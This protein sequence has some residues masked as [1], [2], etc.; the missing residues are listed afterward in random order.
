MLLFGLL[1]RHGE[2]LQAQL[3]P[4]V[5][6]ADREALARAKLI[7][8]GKRGRGFH[9]NLTDTG[10]AWVA[11]HLSAELPPQQ[12]ALSDLLGRLAEHLSR[13]N[14]TLADF[15]GD[16]P[17]ETPPP[18][19]SKPPSPATLRKRIEAAYLKITD[20]RRD[21]AVRLS[22]LR[23]ELSDL[24]RPTVDAALAR[25]LKGD[26]S[27]SLMRQDD[28]RQLNQADRDAAF[29]PAGDPFHV[30]WISS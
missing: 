25:I 22:L 17:E 8:V 15:I 26:K 29:S 11:T 3:A 19:P 10:W 21:E 28:P 14:T 5:K 24:D 4:A 2:S 20:G 23:A 9:L 7:G 16:I 12:R 27:A 6:K 1:A 13:T 30:I 18:K